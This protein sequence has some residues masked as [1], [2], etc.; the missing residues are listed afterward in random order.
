MLLTTGVISEVAL[1]GYE[2]MDPG[3]EV[4]VCESSPINVAVAVGMK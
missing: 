1:E 4:T 3:L 2:A